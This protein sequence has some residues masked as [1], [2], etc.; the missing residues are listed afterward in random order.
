MIKWVEPSLLKDNNT[1]SPICMG[2]AKPFEGL[3]RAM[4]FYNFT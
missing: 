2:Y 1:T 3:G 4:V